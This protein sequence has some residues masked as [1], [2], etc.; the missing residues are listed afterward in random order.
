VIGDLLHGLDFHGDV[1]PVDDVG[2]GFRHRS[3]Q[4]LQDF[5]A[6]R[7]HG[8][9]AKAAISFLPERVKRSIAQ[10]ILIRAGGDEIAAAGLSATPATAPGYDEFEVARRLRIRAANVRGIDADRKLP[11]AIAGEFEFDLASILGLR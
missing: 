2:C 5:S 4:A 3:G 7:N 11:T 8:D 1:K 9:V 10:S 6:V